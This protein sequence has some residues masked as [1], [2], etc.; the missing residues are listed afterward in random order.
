MF[1]SMKSQVCTHRS[2]CLFCYLLLQ[3]VCDSRELE[4]YLGPASMAMRQEWSTPN[5]PTS[6]IEITQADVLKQHLTG[7]DL[8]FKKQGVTI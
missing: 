6:T 4:V 2:L 7:L 3:T 5:S 1:S 8:K